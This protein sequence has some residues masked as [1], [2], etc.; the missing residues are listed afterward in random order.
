MRARVNALAANASDREA[1]HS[2]KPL[3]RPGGKPLR[4]GGK[5]II[6]MYAEDSLHYWLKLMWR[7][8]LDEKRLLRQSMHDIMSETVEIT[9]ND[10]KPLVKVYT[11]RRL[12]EL[13][14]RFGF[15]DISIV[16][17]QLMEAELPEWLTWMPLGTA[18]RLMGWNLIIKAKKPRA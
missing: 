17:R 4:P 14:A 13:F 2:R 10:A 3:L 12:H 5:A 6:M 18:E 8:G 1:R 15:E 11:R 9:E 16:K 7:M